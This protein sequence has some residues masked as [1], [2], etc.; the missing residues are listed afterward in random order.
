M[1]VGGQTRIRTQGRFIDT[2]H[3]FFIAAKMDKANFLSLLKGND[4]TTETT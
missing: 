4:A 3:L 1:R 2:P